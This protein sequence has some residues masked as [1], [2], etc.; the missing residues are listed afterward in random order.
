MS[1]G[2]FLSHA[3]VRFSLRI[4]VQASDRLEKCPAQAWATESEATASVRSGRASIYLPDLRYGG[5]NFI[6]NPA[7]LGYWYLFFLWQCYVLTHI[8]NNLIAR[9]LKEKGRWRL[10]M[11]VAWMLLVLL[12]VKVGGRIS[13]LTSDIW[14]LFWLF[15]LYPIFLLGHII[16]R[17]GYIEKAFLWKQRCFDGTILLF[18]AL[19]ALAVTLLVAREEMV[20]RMIAAPFAVYAIIC[21][22]VKYS[23]KENKGKK[24]LE[25]FGKHSLDIY[26]LHY[27]LIQQ[28]HMEFIGNG[29][30]WMSGCYLVIIFLALVLTVI[31]AATCLAMSWLIRQSR[32]FTFLFLGVK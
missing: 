10:L 27:F 21:L 4:D 24:W 31:I 18:M 12:L 5:V 30:C 15:Q 9:Y 26:V 3:T 13:D 23:G 8:Y 7:K 19:F 11:D 20:R 28:C 29:D 17:E 2:N 25:N 6:E 22:F 1:D 16:Q 32:L 14:G